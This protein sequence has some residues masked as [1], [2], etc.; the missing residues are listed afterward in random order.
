MARHTP[1]RLKNA[2]VHTISLVRKGANRFPVIMKDDGAFALAML[3][4][5]SPKFA[6]D[7][8]LL[9]VVYAP[10]TRDAQGHIASREVVKEMAYSYMRDGQQIDLFHDGRVLEK[11]R[12]FV[13]ENFIVQKGDARFADFKDYDGRPVSTEGAWASVLK[14]EDPA[15]RQQIMSGELNGASLAGIAEIIAEKSDMDEELQK[16]LDAAKAEIAALKKAKD[17]PAPA[18]APKPKPFEGDPLDRKAIEKHL[19]DL[20]RQ[21]ALSKVD[22]SDPAS[23]EAHMATLAKADDTTEAG[24]A[25]DGDSDDVKE[26]RKQLDELQEQLTKAQ[27]VSRRSPSDAPAATG[28][29]KLHVLGKALGELMSERSGPSPLIQPRV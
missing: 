7:G 24:A 15:L 29:D 10:E 19:A 13:A 28:E 5:A 11:S 17:D 6:D 18:P 23:V 22:W 27:K 9:A 20:K 25:G 21:E 3:T 16:Q 26:M 12:A 4:K 14:I 8:E 2:R 1:G